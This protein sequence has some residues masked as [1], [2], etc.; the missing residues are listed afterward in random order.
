MPS[1]ASLHGGTGVSV[2]VVEDDDMIREGIVLTLEEEGFSVMGVADG[3]A[4]LRYLES[5][6]RTG[7]GQP[8]LILLD[9]RM[10]RLDGWSFVEAYRAMP[11]SHAPIVVITAAPDAAK[12]AA[13]I[14]ADGV[15]SKPFDLDDLIAVVEQHVGRIPA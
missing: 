2:L 6:Q 9:M 7:R 12:R 10:P 1:R 8:G 4:A 11:V 5:L 15:I 3:A 13:E 14:G